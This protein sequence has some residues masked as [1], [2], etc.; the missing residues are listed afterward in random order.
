[1]LLFFDAGLLAMGNVRSTAVPTI[2][3]CLTVI[4]F[5]VQILFLCGLALIIGLANTFN[6]F[7]QFT[8]SKMKVRL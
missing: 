4:L 1:M 3:G 8:P 2:L 6:F 5:F 7:F